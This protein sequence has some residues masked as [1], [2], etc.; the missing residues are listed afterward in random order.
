MHTNT[1]RMEKNIKNHQNIMFLVCVC[2]CYVCG[3]GAAAFSLY[4]DT[5]L[6]HPQYI[7]YI[8][9]GFE[10]FALY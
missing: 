1:A 9:N 8:L 4:T 7:Y 2:V 5:H 10:Q 6:H 3:G